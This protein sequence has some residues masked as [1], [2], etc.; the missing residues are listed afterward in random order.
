MS[1]NMCFLVVFTLAVV[2]AQ[3]YAEAPPAEN[4]LTSAA[5][6]AADEAKQVIE[7]GVKT[8]GLAGKTLLGAPLELIRPIIDF[9]QE[10]VKDG[11]KLVDEIV[12]I[13]PENSSTKN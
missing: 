6:G 3:I 1:K 11:E 7:K 12:G 2:I 13:V 10:A 8:A 9:S 4:G 5:K